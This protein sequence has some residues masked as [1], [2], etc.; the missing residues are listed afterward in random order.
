L[1]TGLNVFGLAI[2]ISSCWIIYRIVGYEYSYEKSLP[3]KNNTYR[4]ITGFV[5]DE[6]EQYNGGVCKP[7]YKGIREQVAGLDNVVPVFGLW[8]KSLEVNSPNEKPLSIDEPSEIAATDSTYF[9]MLPYRWILGNK[10]TALSA[11]ETVVLT[12]SRAKKYF[13]NKKPDELLNKTITYYG[14]RDTVTRRVTGIVADY[15]APSEFTTQEFCSLP[16]R[17]YDLATWTNTNGSDKVYLQIRKGTDKNK[18][19]KQIDDLAARKRKEFEQTQ[20]DNFKYKEWYELLPLSES[21]F[22]TYVNEYGVRK[23]SKPVLYGLTGIA[24]FLLVLACINYIN[25]SI[26]S[27]PQRAKEIGVRKT[28][29]SNRTQLIGQ[30]LCETLITAFLGGILSY[31]FSQ[32]GF[33]MLKDI[34][35]PGITP[36]T[37]L[38]QL[39]IFILALSV[40]VMALAGFYPG[41]LITKV[42][43]VNVFKNSSFRQKNKQGFSLQKVLIV[44]QFVIALVFITSAIIVG[45]QMHYAITTDMGFNKDAVVLVDIPWKY[46]TDK[47]YDNKQFSLLAELKTVPGVQDISLGREPMTS[48]YSSSQFEYAREGKESVKRQVF[49]KWVDTAYLNLY[50]M[51]LLAGRNIHASDTVNEYVINETAMHAFG[52]VSPQDAIGKMIGQQNQKFPIVGVVKDF[53]MQDFYTTIDPMAFENDKDRLTTFNIKLGSDASHWQKTLKAVEKKWYEF[54]PP[55]SFSFKFYDEAIAQMYQEEQHLSRLIDLATAISIFISC[56]GLFGLTVLTA[57]Q[58]T[59]EIGI[60]KVLG[61]SVTGIVNLLSKEYIVLIII[62]ICISTPLAWWAMNKWLEKFA[63]RITIEWWM[64]LLAGIIAIIIALITVSFQ[65]IKA[66]IANPVKSLRTE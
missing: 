14:W 35:P 48:N 7:L 64:F 12:E 28:L 61:A 31:A 1:F 43:A 37:S 39:G 17:A 2:S 13:P 42:K 20:A 25:M 22:S 32:L 21:H 66:A 47:K 16:T 29:G 9:D 57:F 46:S 55:E 45:K 41:W 40:M 36:L 38:L 33:W 56:L 51:K 63:Y 8:Q 53:H 26:A 59:K 34:I 19:I 6:K 65:S 10:S 5:F 44:F 54:Y 24:I 3:N 49:R 50:Q 58:R 27:I 18:I 62:A 30:F 4:L 52:F 11:P 60:R 23:A 15:D